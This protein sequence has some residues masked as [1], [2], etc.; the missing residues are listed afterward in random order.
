MLVHPRFRI[1]ILV[2]LAIYHPH[3]NQNLKTVQIPH[4][5]YGSTLAYESIHRLKS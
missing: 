4:E 2:I 1:K 5:P 3:V